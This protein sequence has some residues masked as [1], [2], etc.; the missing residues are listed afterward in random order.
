VRKGYT[1]IEAVAATAIAS[2]SAAVLCTVVATF[3]TLQGHTQKVSPSAVELTLRALRRD[4][5]A[6]IVYGE[7]PFEGT[8]TTL[9][10][11]CALRVFD[12]RQREWTVM[13]TQVRYRMLDGA[14]IRD[15]QK[16][17]VTPQPAD[18]RSR[19]VLLEGVSALSF[20]YAAYDAARKTLQWSNAYRG[21][22]F[23]DAVRVKMTF[24]GMRV[25]RSITVYRDAA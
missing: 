17:A 2:L 16:S 12:Q 18:D 10:A 13:P 6:A 14:F 1:L 20:E 11:M 7:H 25:Q 3:S 4:I 19:T 23:P 8:P 15:A 22:G 9:R 21:R 24:Q 5:C